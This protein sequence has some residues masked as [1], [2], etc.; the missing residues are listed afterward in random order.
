VSITTPP[1]QTVDASRLMNKKDAAQYVGLSEAFLL[2]L[3]RQGRIRSYKVG[4]FVKFHPTDLDGYVTSCA[5]H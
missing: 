2:R 3:A 4:R 1:P 5:R